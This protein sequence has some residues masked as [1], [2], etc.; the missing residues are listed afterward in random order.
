LRRITLVGQIDWDQERH[1]YVEL[2]RKRVPNLEGLGFQLHTYG[3]YDDTIG[4]YSPIDTRQ[5]RT[6]LMANLLKRFDS[7]IA[8]TLEAIVK[9]EPQAAQ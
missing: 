9:P 3:H 4:A 1:H 8:F 2:L 7:P 5:Y 6:W